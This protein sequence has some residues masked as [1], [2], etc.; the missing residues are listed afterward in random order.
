VYN[1]IGVLV[2]TFTLNEGA[3]MQK[4]DPFLQWVAVIASI[5]WL[6]WLFS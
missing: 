6:I 2:R 3:T 1:D 5:L 4:G